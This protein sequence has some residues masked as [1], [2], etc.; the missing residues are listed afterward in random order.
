MTPQHR[1]TGVTLYDLGVQ[2]VNVGHGD[3]KDGNGR[4]SN[5]VLDDDDEGQP[6]EVS[7]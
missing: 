1:E 3:G 2:S 5:F 4:G 6:V 7:K